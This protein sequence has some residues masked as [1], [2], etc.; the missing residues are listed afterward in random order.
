M[1]TAAQARYV[2]WAR[3]RFPDLRYD[4]ATVIRPIAGTSSWSQHSY[5]NAVDVWGSPARLEALYQETSRNRPWLAV[6]TLCYNRRGGCTTPHTDHVH[7]DFH[8]KQVGDPRGSGGTGPSD[9][10]HIPGAQGVTM[11]VPEGMTTAETEAALAGGFANPLD[12]L[13]ALGNPQTYMRGLWL[14]GG[15][16]LVLVGVSRLLPAGALPGPAGAIAR[17]VK[18]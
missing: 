12:V 17:M 18:P 3:G 8:P 11:P 13:R 7:V 5:G 2:E 1:G 15:T 16:A 10:V 9:R 14:L 4:T 6:R